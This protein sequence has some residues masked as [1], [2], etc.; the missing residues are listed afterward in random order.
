MSNIIAEIVH[1]MTTE[2][3]EEALSKISPE[4][5]KIEVSEPVSGVLDGKTFENKEFQF[6]YD[7]DIG[8]KKESEENSEDISSFKILKSNRSVEKPIEIPERY[9]L[10]QQTPKETDEKKTSIQKEESK[11]DVVFNFYNCTVHFGVD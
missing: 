7:T 10:A 8:L 9:S 2:E 4:T 6:S 5:Q 11:R 3:F 1:H